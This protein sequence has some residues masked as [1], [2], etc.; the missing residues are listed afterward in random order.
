MSLPVSFT[1]VIIFRH[2]SPWS[3][4]TISF[5]N[6]ARRGLQFELSFLH[7]LGDNNVLG[8]RFLFRSKD[9]SNS[10]N[11]IK[12]LALLIM[13]VYDTKGINS[14]VLSTTGKILLVMT[15]ERFGGS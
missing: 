7:F 6:Y 1:V 13:T 12:T 8:K 5:E 9:C 3:V 2:R 15:F 11:T 14:Y 4:Q 10:S